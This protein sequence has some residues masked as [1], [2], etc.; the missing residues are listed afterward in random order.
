VQRVDL[1]HRKVDVLFE[2]GVQHLLGGLLQLLK[3]MLSKRNSQESD[4][5]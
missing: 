5:G 1:L 3:I 2:D 4:S